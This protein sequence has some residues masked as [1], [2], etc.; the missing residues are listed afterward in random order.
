MATMDDAIRQ[1]I[2]RNDTMQLISSSEVKAIDG[3]INAIGNNTGATDILTSEISCNTTRCNI[4]LSR[5]NK[6]QNSTRWTVTDQSSWPAILEN[7]Y[8]THND[9]QLQIAKLFP[10]TK[11]TKRLNQQVSEQDYLT[12][13]ELYSKMQLAGQVTPELMLSLDKLIKQAPYLYS[14]YSL[15]RESALDF[16]AVTNDDKFILLFEKIL[17]QTPPE[18]RYSIEQTIRHLCIYWYIRES[19]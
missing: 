12:Y 7:F 13:I 15:F 18:Y 14:A 5:L 9:T 1:Y 17:A 6:S 3:D 19:K 16:Y 8:A 2:I 10:A 4:T 11:P